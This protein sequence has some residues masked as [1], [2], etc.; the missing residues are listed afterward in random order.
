MRR[1]AY[2]L[3]VMRLTVKE[4]FR[5]RKIITRSAV[6]VGGIFLALR[7]N[8]ECYRGMEKG[9]S[10][11]LG[12]L[13]PSLFFF[14]TVA[15]YIVQSGIADTLCKPLKGLTRLLFHLPEQSAA[16]ILLAVIGGYPVGAAS[17][18]LMM[19]QRRLSPS[20]A[21]KTSY[22]AVAAGPG[23]LVNFIGGALL[24]NKEAGTVLLISQVIAVILTGIIIG[25]T[26]KSEPL[27]H[28]CAPVRSGG[29]LLVSAVQSASRSAFGM[30]AMVVVFC[31]LSEVADAVITTP[32]LCDILS[33]MLE[34]TNGCSR[35]CTQYPLYMTAFFVGFGGLSVHFQIFSALGEVPVKKYLF[36][37]FRII[38]GII[39]GA[40][41]Y[42]Y[43]MV[44]PMTVTTFSSLSN[45]PSASRSA[46]LAGSAA[47]VLSS[48][49][50]IG[51]MAKKSALI[52]GQT[53]QE[54]I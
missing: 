28:T 37:L 54:T 10:L 25:H 19:Q 27:P 5:Y 49:L 35:I 45:A 33:A 52:R 15:A 48:I 22:I 38:E 51:S 30:C 26:V 44:T 43:L 47:L 9:I 42:I 20:Q 40:A 29:N 11:C 3:S 46:T 14:M 36:F 4:L 13:I 16:V 50:F 24:R 12:V 1:Q 39:T 18:S 17:A 2:I 8:N 21:A 34:I 6:A 32:G 41:T 31:A 23:F 7:F 53:D